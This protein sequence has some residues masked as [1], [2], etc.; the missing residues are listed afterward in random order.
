MHVCECVDAEARAVQTLSLLAF[1]FAIFRSGALDLFF[2][3][4]VHGRTSTLEPIGP[5]V[6]KISPSVFFTAHPPVATIMADATMHH[7]VEII[8]EVTEGCI[9]MGSSAQC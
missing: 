9:V 4:A 2:C 5:V 6:C 8:E 1:L 3:P 7:E